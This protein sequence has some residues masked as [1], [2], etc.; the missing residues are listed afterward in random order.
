M[1]DDAPGF[2]PDD[3]EV[4]GHLAAAGF[5][6][7]PLGPQHNDADYQAWTSSMS[8]IQATP[9]SPDEAGRIP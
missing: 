1:S 7:E 8:H 4:P 6:L 2:V 9:D 5:W 3:F